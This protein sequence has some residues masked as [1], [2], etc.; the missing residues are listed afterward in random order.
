VGVCSTLSCGSPDAILP[1]HSATDELGSRN[2]I[3][4]RKPPTRGS[5]AS[6]TTSAPRPSPAP[7]W[8]PR[9]TERSQATRADQLR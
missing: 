4:L 5:D 2:V 6:S 3:L 8:A 7:R 1:T 9:A